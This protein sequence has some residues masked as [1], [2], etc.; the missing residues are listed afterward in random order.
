MTLLKL[1]SSQ[2]TITELEVDAI[3]N[4]ANRS[5]LGASPILQSESVLIALPKVEVEVS[6]PS[7]SLSM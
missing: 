4:A 7:Y 1:I 2:G 5:L 6:L 3:V